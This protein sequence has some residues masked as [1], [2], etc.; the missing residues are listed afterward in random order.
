RSTPA[1]SSRKARGSTRLELLVSAPAELRWVTHRRPDGAPD[2]SSQAA[3]PLPLSL[4]TNR[5]LTDTPG[6]LTPLRVLAI[7]TLYFER[8]YGNH[9]R[10]GQWESATLTR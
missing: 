4:R 6:S 8:V 7:V 2:R 1:G 9:R 10:V 5:A 3:T